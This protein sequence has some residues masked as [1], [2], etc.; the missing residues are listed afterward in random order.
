MTDFKFSKLTKES[1]Q[2]V[3][4]KRIRRSLENSLTESISN[5]KSIRKLDLS[6]KKKENLCLFFN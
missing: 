1:I 6:P 4:D 2:K 3:L 5:S